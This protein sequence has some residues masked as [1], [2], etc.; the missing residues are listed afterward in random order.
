[1]SLLEH[2]LAR[3]SDDGS[4][5]ELRSRPL[6]VRWTFD[7]LVTSDGH[8]IRCD[9]ECSVRALEDPTEQKMLR[10][11][12]L[13]G[14]GVLTGDE[15]AAHFQD[16]LR[17]AA[18]G[19]FESTTAST[20]LSDQGRQ[21]ILDALKIAARPL[22]FSSGVEMLAPFSVNIESPTF[23]Q[24]R[25]N[26]MQRTLAE[27]HAVGQLEHFQ[28][29][30]ELL[31]QFHMIRESA[32]Q[33]SAGHVLQQ[34]NPADQGSLLQSLL[35][36][37]ARERPSTELWAAAGPKLVR[38]DSRSGSFRTQTINLPVQLG[39][40]RSITLARLSDGR[41]LLVGARS[42][43]APIRP[44]GSI[45]PGIYHDPDI[46]SDLGF[47]RVIY[48]PEWTAYVGCHGD[49]GIVHWAQ[50][51]PQ[52]P[53]FAIRTQTLLASYPGSASP[54][55]LQG[56]AGG[57]IIFSLGSRLLG[58]DADHNLFSIETPSG[59]EIVAILPDGVSRL[60]VVHADGVMCAIDAG[61]LQVVGEHRVAACVRTAGTLPWLGTTRLLLAS[62][63]GPIQC[64]GIDDPIVTQYIS[65]YPGGKIVAGSH[66]LV[67]AVSSDRQ[68]LVIWN[69]W[70]GRRPIADL[71]MTA[72][73][74]HRVADIEFA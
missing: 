5:L 57:R 20:G 17:N 62:D 50:S 65:P 7:H 58:M 22:A 30:A 43:F 61:A 25:L 1:M 27:R 51:N 9:F 32:P 26:D 45:E 74:R 44:D 13:D 48:V 18:T 47:N 31:K 64:V 68:R 28:R 42:G 16:T 40:I 69:T 37:S 72:L 67:A 12:L 36:A 23:Q 56:V 2:E 8:R 54:R 46:A 11:V 29:A 63:D 14:R 24:Q 55:N 34:V 71:L 49:G 41:A 52:K 6:R 73:T 15:V 35:L 19:V 10:E 53:V 21:A 39:P 3:R 59:A 4:T 38:I 33:L 60:L 70:D 66:E